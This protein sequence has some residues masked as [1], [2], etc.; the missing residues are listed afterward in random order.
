M[1]TNKRFCYLA[2]ASVTIAFLAFSAMPGRLRAQGPSS[3]SVDLAQ[4]IS[5]FEVAS[6]QA[7]RGKLSPYEVFSIIQY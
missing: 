7:L 5:D 3:V 4:E 6:F 1:M 2:L